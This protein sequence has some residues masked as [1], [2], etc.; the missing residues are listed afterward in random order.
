MQVRLQAFLQHAEAGA[1]ADIGAEREV[2]AA[3]QV[4]AHGKDAAAERGVAARAVATRCAVRRQ[5]LQLGVGGVDVVRE[6]RMR[7]RPDRSARRPRGSRRRPGNSRATSA[8][9][10]RDLV[11]VRLEAHAGIFAQQRLADFEHRFRA[12]SAKRGVTA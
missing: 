5:A 8:T 12:E 3:R 7:G 4:A 2:N 10:G 9:S 6:D 1:A 11:E